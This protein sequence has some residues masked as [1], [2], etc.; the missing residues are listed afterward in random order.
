MLGEMRA[1]AFALA[2]S[3]PSPGERAA[4][5]I[6]ANAGGPYG[7]A[8]TAGRGVQAA[9]DKVWESVKAA[10]GDEPGADWYKAP[11]TIEAREEGEWVVRAANRGAEAGWEIAPAAKAKAT[12][13]QKVSE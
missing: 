5:T 7:S 6:D 13:R 10:S 3:L 1:G 9:S 11:L 12:K 8:C 4:Q 2:S